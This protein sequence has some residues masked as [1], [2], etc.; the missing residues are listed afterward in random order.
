M[1]RRLLWRI[2][3]LVLLFLACEKGSGDN[4]WITRGLNNSGQNVIFNVTPGIGAMVCI[5]RY[6]WDTDPFFWMRSP[7]FVTFLLSREIRVSAFFFS[8]PFFKGSEITFIASINTASMSQKEER[9]RFACAVVVKVR[10]RHIVWLMWWKI[11]LV[12][13]KN[14]SLWT[15]LS[16]PDCWHDP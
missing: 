9:F 7:P 5:L 3:T 12:L 4:E 2:Q 16:M 1:A 13:D 10:L 8:S 14:Y 11:D 15:V 6:A